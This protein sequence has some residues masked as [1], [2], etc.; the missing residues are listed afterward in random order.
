MPAT[1]EE[2]Q[3][4]IDGLEVAINEAKQVVPPARNAKAFAGGQPIQNPNRTRTDHSFWDT[5]EE[6]GTE[7]ELPAG[8]KPGTFKSFGEFVR[9]GV[10]NPLNFR[11]NYM[12]AIQGLNE[13]VGSE[14]GFMVLPEFSTTILEKT[15]ANAIWTETDNYSV[16]GNS[17]TFPR[18]AESS[19]ATG[20]RHGGLRAYWVD[21]GDTITGSKPQLGRLSLRLKKLAVVVYLT[22]ELI[23][24]TGTALQ[25]YTSRKVASEFNFMLGDAFFNGTGVGQPRGFLNAP[26]LVTVQRATAAQINYADVVGMYARLWPGSLPNAR[27]YYNQDCFPRLAQMV[28]ATGTYSGQPVYLPPGGASQ[29]PYG[30][31]LG[32]PAIPV[33]FAETLGTEGDLSLCDPKQYISIGKGGIQQSLST[34]VEFLTDQLAVKFVIRIDGDCWEPSATTPYKGT[35]TTSSF[36]TLTDAA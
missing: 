35:A 21:E 32:L 22:Q 18:N 12:K 5:S 11:E 28:I 33:E 9:M 2:L 36:V 23:D 34:H 4:K 8:Y 24:D 17:I 25:Q 7:F 14:G 27:W 13:T 31:L 26:C 15:Y 20:S 10:Q 29:S 30:S 3:A 1:V 16:G 6:R 19:R